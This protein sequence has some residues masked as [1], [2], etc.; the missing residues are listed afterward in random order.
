M[1]ADAGAGVALVGQSPQPAGVV[2]VQRGQ[3]QLAG[4]GQVV[5]RAGPDRG[6]PQRK[7]GRV[8]HDLHVAAEG[9]VLAGVL[10]V[11]AALGTGSDPV[12]GDQHAVQTGNTTPARRAPATTCARSG[13]SAAQT[14]AVRC[15]PPGA[16]RSL[17]AAVYVEAGR[18]CATSMPAT[19]TA[20]HWR[21]G[22][23]ST[24]FAARSGPGSRSST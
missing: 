18:L 22:G 2:R 19:A 11:M 1:D 8:E 24:A 4:G 5:G 20:S 7:A 15:L 21:A 13:A 9:V 14:G 12:G 3:H 16:F 17:V 23:A 6:D 10:Q